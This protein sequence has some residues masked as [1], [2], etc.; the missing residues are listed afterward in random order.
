[1][2]MT[3]KHL[4]IVGVSCLAA[5]PSFADVKLNDNFSISG[6][7]VGSYQYIETSGAGSSDSFNLDA[8]KVSLLAKFDEVS[9]D[10]GVYYTQTAAGTNNL[11]LIDANVTYD[12]GGG[13]TITGGRFLSWMGYEAF[14]SINKNQASSAYINPNGTIMFY[15]AYHEG[16]KVKYSLDNVTLGAA[17]L[18]SLNGPTIYRGDGELKHNFGSEVFVAFDPVKNLRIWTGVGYDSPGALASQ[19]VSTTV[20]NIWVQYVIGD[21]T[22]AAECIHQ[23]TST[24]GTGTDGMVLLDYAFTKKVSAAFRISTGK[25]DNTAVAQGLGFTK[26]TVSPTV[27]ITDHLAIRP[28]ISYIDYK[29]DGPI[30]HDTFYAVQALFK[31]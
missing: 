10:F 31:F 13:L 3:K 29:N 8:S 16:V 30:N 2:I 26:F 9:A 27:A 17:L 12:A 25:L 15:P 22:L 20:Y 6:Y 11:T 5:A 23:S 14:D 7:A 19:V 21:V 28:E 24:P 4:V 18:D 1:M